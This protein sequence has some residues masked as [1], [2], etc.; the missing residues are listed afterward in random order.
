MKKVFMF[1]C[2]LCVSVGFM[3]AQDCMA[4]FPTTEGAT[5]TTKSYDGNNNLISTTT[6]TVGENYQYVSGATAE[7]AFRSVDMN[8]NVVDMGSMEARCDDGNFYLKRLNRSI[9]P[10]CQELVFENIELLGNFLDYPNT[11][12]SP[13]PFDNT[14]EMD[15]AEFT[16][17]NKDDKDSFMRVRVY[18]RDYEKNEKIN[19]PAG[20]FDAA[21]ITYVVEVYD[22][23][24]KETKNYKGI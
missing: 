20:D 17:K 3:S 10:D 9:I 19:T 21:K 18:N 8:G 7:I 24:K 5:M 12:S 15:G 14:F 6:Y 4:M 22:S 2:L 11:F 1:V 16:I 13:Y 23:A